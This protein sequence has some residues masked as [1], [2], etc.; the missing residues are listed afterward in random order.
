M[1]KKY[2]KDIFLELTDEIDYIIGILMLASSRA[3]VN[4]HG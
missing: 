1:K 3:F 4:S 2:K